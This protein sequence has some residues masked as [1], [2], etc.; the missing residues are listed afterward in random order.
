MSED[1]QKTA[2]PSKPYPGPERRKGERRK[3]QHDRR[4]MFRFE[5]EKDP[6][7]SG[8]DRRRANQDVWKQR[9]I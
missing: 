7:R 1:D 3:A 5:P 4:E 6:R 8:Q 9:D 2:P